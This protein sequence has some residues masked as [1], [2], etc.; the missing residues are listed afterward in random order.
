MATSNLGYGFALQTS[1]GQYHQRHGRTKGS[2]D[3]QDKELLG[4]KTEV[5]PGLGPRLGFVWM[6]FLC[7]LTRDDKGIDVALS[8]NSMDEEL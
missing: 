8:M 4:L 2:N 5:P 1:E 3:I 6:G 7:N